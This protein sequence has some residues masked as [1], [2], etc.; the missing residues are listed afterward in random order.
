MTVP[1]RGASQPAQRDAR[2]RRGARVRRARSRTAPRRSPRWTPRGLPS[3]RSSVEP[4]GEA[5]ADQRRVQLEPRLGARRARAARAGRT[6]DAS[7]WPCSARCAS[8]ARTLRARARGGRA[9]RARVRRADRGGH[10]RVRRGAAG[11]RAGRRAGRDA[12]R[13]ST[14][15]GRC[16]ASRLAADAVILLKASRGVRLE[17][18]LPHLTAW[19]AEDVVSLPNRLR[20][21]TRTMLYYFLYPLRQHFGPFRVFSTCRSGRRAPR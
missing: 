6:R 12:R 1:L 21:V 16:C 20:P 19:A 5:L 11:G 9:R 14:T 4:L 18:L 10:R 8:S 7:A 17:R 3:M 15:S 2:A 13:T